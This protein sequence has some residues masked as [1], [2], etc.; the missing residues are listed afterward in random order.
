MG[1]GL[2]NNDCGC[3]QMLIAGTHDGH[4]QVGP[5]VVNGFIR[6]SP[7]RTR[8]FPPVLMHLAGITG[9]AVTL[10]HC[11]YWKWRRLGH[12]GPRSGLVW[13]RKEGSDQSLV[14]EQ[15]ALSCAQ[16]SPFPLW[17]RHPQKLALRKVPLAEKRLVHPG[18]CAAALRRGHP[19]PHPARV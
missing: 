2:L 4:T 5:I 12:W 9:L 19:A 17:K 7:C 13:G 14:V 3:V 18:G 1:G 10:W 15:A 6:P 16:R 8:A 11:P